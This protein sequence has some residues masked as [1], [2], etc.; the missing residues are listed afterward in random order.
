MTT[1]TKSGG[2][3]QTLTLNPVAALPGSFEL[4]I[5]SQ[6]L[7]AK[8]P[9]AQRVQ[10]RVIVTESA[11]SDLR[12]VIDHCLAASSHPEGERKW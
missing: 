6:L 5:Q 10:H 3:T 11:L 8:D 1:L 4:I 7:S 2:Y 12:I 9:T